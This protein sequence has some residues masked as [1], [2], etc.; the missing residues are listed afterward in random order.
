MKIAFQIACKNLMGAGLR[1]WLNVGVLS[2]VFV[3]IILFNGL[4]EGWSEQSIDQSIEW[5]YANGHLLNEDYDPLDPF[6]IE[7]GHGNINDV[8][9]AGLTPVLIRQATIYPQGRMKTILLKG[10]R[11][12]QNTIK[13]PTQALDSSSA[14][15]PAIIG[16]RTAEVANLTEGDQVL[17]RWRDKNGTFDAADITIAEIFNT[18]VAS[19]DNGQIWI[20]IEKLW[21]MTDLKNEAT[22]LIADDS[23]SHQNVDGWR[24]EN[25]DALL[26]EFRELIQ[27][28]K[29]S[30]SILYLVLLIIA[31]IAIFDTQVLSI[32]RR[33][34]EIGTYVALG[35][36]RV[37]VL[38]L[39]TVEG[40]LYSV[41]GVIAGLIYGIPLFIWVNEV[42]ISFPD[43][44]QDMGINMP[45]TIYPEFAVW[46]IALTAVILILSATLVSLIPAR[47]IVQMNP[48]NA[49]K[50]K[51]Q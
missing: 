5:E 48:V 45:S 46:L 6:S 26:S 3:I 22:Y 35:M 15:I 44:Y 38:R 50:G 20:S 40:A 14:E 28:E 49:L 37:E 4:I 10:I 1:T 51:I 13:L 16:V 36:T 39:F 12:D 9:T 29:Y 7:D 19:V 23:Y 31:L 17:L 42:G 32:F 43:Y 27:I 8:S 33:Q 25:Q 2:F 34:K 21:Q 18:S 30:S 41:F 47:K 11:S 24:F